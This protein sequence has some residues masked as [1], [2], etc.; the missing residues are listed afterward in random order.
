MTQETCERLATHYKEKGMLKE[1][2]DINLSQKRREQAIKDAA[3]K[4]PPENP[5]LTKSFASKKK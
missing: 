4:Q 3:A 1:L 5:N 2:A